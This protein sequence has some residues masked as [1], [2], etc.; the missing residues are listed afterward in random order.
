MK[1]LNN[2]TQLIGNLG[3]DAEVINL[4]NGKAMVAFSLATTD[5][6]T[7]EA[8]QKVEDTQWHNCLVFRKDA[9]SC[10]K[11]AQYLKKGTQLIV[12][13]KLTYKKTTQDV[14]GTPVTH[15]NANV[16]INEV[17]FVG[18]KKDDA[19]TIAEQVSSDS[20]VEPE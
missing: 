20:S 15:T 3:K 13:G 6:W 11:L 19:N 5:K 8:G 18:G 16:I 10:N 12:E 9:E 2:T 17:R 1:S 4:T 7:N 14:N